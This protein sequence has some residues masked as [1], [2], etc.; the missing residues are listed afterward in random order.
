MTSQTLDMNAGSLHRIK[1][2][3]ILG[4]IQTASEV[5]VT[6]PKRAS[7][8]VAIDAK[9]GITVYVPGFHTKRPKIFSLRAPL[10]L[11]LES[12]PSV[13]SV[14]LIFTGQYIILSSIEVFL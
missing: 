8:L 11:L 5:S 1:S 2:A 6:T 13:P 14:Q 9:G 7:G 3:R 4:R 12:L 10:V